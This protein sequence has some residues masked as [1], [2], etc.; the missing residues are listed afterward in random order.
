LIRSGRG[1]IAS[2]FTHKAVYVYDHVH[3]HDNI[4]AKRKS[5][6]VEVLVDVDVGGF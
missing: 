5:V 1:P 4:Y 2:S 6:I 3:E